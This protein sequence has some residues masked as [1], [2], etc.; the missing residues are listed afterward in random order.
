MIHPVL[1]DVGRIREL[2]A[3]KP[4][5]REAAIATTNAETAEMLVDAG[6]DFAFQYAVVARL[7]AEGAPA[8]AEPI[9]KDQDQ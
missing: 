6:Y 8:F 5:S 9:K 2:L 4:S 1:R 3:S 7:W